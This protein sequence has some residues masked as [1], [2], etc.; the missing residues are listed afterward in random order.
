[1]GLKN[2]FNREAKSTEEAPISE[3]RLTEY[4]RRLKALEKRVTV[5]E[6]VKDVPTNGSTR[7]NGMGDPRRPSSVPKP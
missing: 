6:R 5:L 4:E 2:W 7:R 3:A 1:M